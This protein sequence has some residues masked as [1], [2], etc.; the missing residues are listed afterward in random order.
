MINLLCSFRQDDHPICLKHD[1]HLD[2][3]WCSELLHSWDGFSFFLMP[4]WAPLPEF[5]VSSD[6]AGS[7]GFATIFNN[8]GFCGTWSASQQPLSITHKELFPIVVAAYV[9]GLQWA[10][11]RVEFLCN[12]ESM[13][14]LL[15]SGNS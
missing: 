12:N 10:S 14:A 8:Q 13:V 2:M 6:A 3:T 11:W 15:S 9:W 5:Q 7:Q 1:F 4:G